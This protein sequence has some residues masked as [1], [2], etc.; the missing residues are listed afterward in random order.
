MDVKKNILSNAMTNKSN[1]L[2]IIKFLAALLV[3]WSHA[4]A[5]VGQDDLV[6][7]ISRGK[8]TGGMLAVAVFFFTGGLLIAKSAEKSHNAMAYF[9]KR[10][11]R[12]FPLLMIVVVCCTFVLG[13][14]MTSLSIKEYFTNPGTYRYLLNGILV[15]QH[16]LPGV[17]EANPVFATVNGSLWTLPVEFLCY[18]ACWILYKLG[19]FEKKRIP[20]IFAFYLLLSISGYAI[21]NKM[22]TFALLFSV[23]QPCYMFLLGICVYVFRD[24]IILDKRIFAFTVICFCACMFLGVGTLAVW[25]FYPYIC[26]FLAYMPKQVHR[27]ISKVGNYSYGIYL[28]A[29]PIQQTILCVSNGKIS[30]I[31]HVCI[32]IV[33]AVACGWGLSK[34]ESKCI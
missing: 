21:T 17:F 20:F 26:L 24:R 23:V 7:L 16:N 22:P 5:L 1:N 6:C 32:A 19:F 28:C 10:C 13:P 14:I 4:Y 3:I 29:Y 27:A 34:I 12:I 9:K 33:L 2:Q 30:I 31:A 15:L 8:Q 18:I 11:I 25:T